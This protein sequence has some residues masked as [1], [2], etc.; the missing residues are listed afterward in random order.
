MWALPITRADAVVRAN[1][2]SA[3]ARRSALTESVTPLQ[4]LSKEVEL[5]ASTWT[6]KAEAIVM[7]P[8]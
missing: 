8:Q 4:E 6:I 5:P 3:S 1:G 2:Y 7:L